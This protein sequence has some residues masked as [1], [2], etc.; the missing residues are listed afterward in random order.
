MSTISFC[1]GNGSCLD[2]FFF[3]P[4]LEFFFPSDGGNINGGGPVEERDRGPSCR[5]Q[6]V[7]YP[8]DREGQSRLP[9]QP[10]L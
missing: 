9:C 1:H 4:L 7:F 5:K 8:R 6:F 10:I 2:L 3:F